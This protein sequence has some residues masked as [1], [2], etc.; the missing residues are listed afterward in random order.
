MLIWQKMAN[1]LN[2]AN[3]NIYFLALINF[4]VFKASEISSDSL[5]NLIWTAFFE[6]WELNDEIHF[7]NP[8]RGAGVS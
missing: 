4:S 1:Y 6:S 5:Q 3:G 7:K 2:L 8:C